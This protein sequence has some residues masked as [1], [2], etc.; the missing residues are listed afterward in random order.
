MKKNA[1]VL[2][3]ATLA[4]VLGSVGSASA[5]SIKWGP[6]FNKKAGHATT[7]NCGDDLGRLRRVFPQE[8][9]SVYDED[10]VSVLPIC[11]GEDVGLLR[12][13]GNAGALR[14]H[15][16]QNEAMVVAL[17]DRDFGPEDVVGVRMTGKDKVILYVYS[18]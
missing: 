9:Q 18:N 8:I 13:E 15:I 10:R 1:F 11:E 3:A 5:L 4:V 7:Y 6:G 12:S 17:G 2:A 14:K 16:A